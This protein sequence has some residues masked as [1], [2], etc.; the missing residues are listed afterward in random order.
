MSKDMGAFCIYPLLF[1]SILLLLEEE[2]LQE[3]VAGK[4][5]TAY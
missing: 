4:Q 2:Y 5:Y 3:E 1:Y